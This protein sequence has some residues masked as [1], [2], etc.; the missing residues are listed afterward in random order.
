MG[1]MQDNLGACM[2][3]LGT[4]LDTYTDLLNILTFVICYLLFDTSGSKYVLH[5]QIFASTH[6]IK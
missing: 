6:L 3:L 2:R 5:L 4:F 1:E